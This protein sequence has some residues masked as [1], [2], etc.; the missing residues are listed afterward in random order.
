MIQSTRK[1]KSKNEYH[2]F[3][4]GA[5]VIVLASMVVL[6]GCTLQGKDKEKTVTAPAVRGISVDGQVVNSTVMSDHLD[7][8][9]TIAANQEVDMVS[10]LT[11]KII[12]VHAHEGSLVKA[13]ALLF[14]LDGADLQAQLDQLQQREKLAALSEARLR[15]L[16]QH[17]AAIQQDYDQAVTNLNVLR[18]EIRQLTVTLEKTQI[19]APFDG[20]IG[21][22]RAY[23]GALVSSNTPLTNLVDDSQVKIEFAVP[24]KYAN[25]IAA[26]S[27]Q[28]FTVESDN[29]EYTAKVIARESRLNETTRTLLI[30][31]ISPNP[32]RT[33][34]PGQSARIKLTVHTANDALL[35]SSQ[36]LIP[37]S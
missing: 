18:A 25:M 10:E 21:I 30:R 9:G 4:T 31:A 26:G 17:D 2:Y 35:V 29:K 28:R 24:E 16:I 12:R 8:A 32:G 33:L 6:G 37:S 5:W 7:V 13:G 3:R 22:I 11:R 27:I 15:D 19:R 20:R 14:Q 36:A 1:L 34:L 23:P